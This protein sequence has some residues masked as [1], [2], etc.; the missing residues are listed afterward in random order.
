M[1]HLIRLIDY[2]IVDFFVQQAEDFR[3]RRNQFLKHAPYLLCDGKLYR[4]SGYFPEKASYGLV[5]AETPGHRKNVVLEAAQCGSGYL[6]SKA[7]ALTLAE[8]KIGLAILEYDFEC[9][10]PGVNL[11]CFEEINVSVSSKQPVPFAVLSPTHEKDSDLYPSENGVI[12]N[13]VAFEFA[14]VFL[15]FKSLA[16]SDQG[17]CGHVT[18]PGMVF[19]LSILADFYHAQPMTF[20]MSAMDETDNFLVGEP[21]VGQYISELYPFADSPLYH[22][23][24]KFDFGHVVCLFPFTEYLAV[25]SGRATAAKFLRTHPVSAFPALF[26]DD[27]EIEKK[28]RHSVGDGHAETLE[29]QNRL[30]GQMGMYASYPL[31]GATG[32]FM[33]CVVKNQTYVLR[34]MSGTKTYLIPQLNG[35]VP[36]ALRQSISG[37][38]IKR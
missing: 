31:D 23:L 11:P 33:V 13:I 17:R 4:L 27:V 15:Q 22:L 6:G 7:G 29:S 3:Y 2:G 28:L 26:T 19:G 24:C 12:H 34:L 37:F 25:M 20:Y 9:P 16:K 18:I 32:L 1:G 30:M 35:Y 14:T 38:P 8:A 36:N 21:T 5:V 10:A